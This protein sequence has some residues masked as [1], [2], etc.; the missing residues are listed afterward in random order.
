MYDSILQAIGNTPLLRL[1]HLD[2]GLPGRVWVKLENRNPGGSIK[3]RVALHLLRSALATGKV[4]PGGVV[5]EGTSGN[6]GIGISLVA[7]AL[8]LKPVIAM[9]ESM[10]IERRKIMQAFG[11]ELI[12]TPGPAGMAGAVAAAEQVVAERG[13]YL[14][15][16]FTN[17]LALEAHY[18]TTGPEIYEATGGRAAVLLA[19][20]GSGSSLC[21]AGRYL[22]ERIPGFRMIAVEPALSPVLSGGKPASHPIQ[23]IGANFIPAIV[24]LSLIDEILQA[25]GDE[26]MDFARRMITIE[27]VSC[28]ISSGSNVAMALKVAAR[29]ESE[30]KDI[31]TFVTDTGERYLSTALFQ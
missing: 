1:S 17:P 29:P 8:G 14:V 7:R 16:Q 3:D 23:G 26:A 18:T 6:M 27:G 25:D 11:A 20:V 12:L 31:I 13:G 9:P 28:G 19:G 15:G 21:G 24:D 5:C 4:K 2:K 30:G 10:S 22:K